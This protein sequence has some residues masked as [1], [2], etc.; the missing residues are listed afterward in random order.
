MTWDWTQVSWSIDK[1]STHLVNEPVGEAL[2]LGHWEVWI[3]LSLPLLPGQLWLEK[4][5]V[6]RVIFIGQKDV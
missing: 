6:V 3:T 1:H 4:V 5:V 2:F